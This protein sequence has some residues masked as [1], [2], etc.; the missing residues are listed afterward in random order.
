MII[1]MLSRL[2]P[3]PAPEIPPGPLPWATSMPSDSAK[4]VSIIQTFGM[5]TA[6]F[7]SAFSAGS[8]SSASILMY[9]FIFVQGLVGNDGL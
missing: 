2:P 3:P 8:L 6:S 1:S 7:L 5:S 9:V 4:P